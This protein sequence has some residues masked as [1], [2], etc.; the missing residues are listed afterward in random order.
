MKPV[1]IFIAC[2]SW[3]GGSKHRP[4]LV[5]SQDAENIEVFRITTQYESKSRAIRAKYFK[6][7]DRQQAGL[8]KQSYV[9]TGNIRKLPI[10]TANGT[11][12]IGRLS[13]KDKQ[14]LLAFLTK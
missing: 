8:D 7:N 13:M 10:D 1:D 5:L 11:T 14:G 4:V 6:I 9:D 2:V 12:P 3:Q